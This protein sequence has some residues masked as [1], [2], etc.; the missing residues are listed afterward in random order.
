MTMLQEAGNKTSRD[1]ISASYRAQMKGS[2]M[3]IEL[4]RQFYD[5]TRSFRVTGPSGAY[6]FVDVNNAA[7]KD[8]EM[9]FDSEGQM[10]YRKPVFDLKIKAQKKNPFSR[11]EQNERAKELYGMGFFNPERAQE[12]MCALEMMDF[13]GID[14]VKEQVRQ[15]QTLLNM[16]Q[17]LNML[18][19]QLT[20][21]AMM[22]GGQAAE[23]GAAD[24]AGGETLQRKAVDAQKANMTSYGQRLAARSGPNMNAG[25]NSAM[26]GA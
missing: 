2:A 18:I 15:G 17:Q 21:A 3:C 26:P 6:Q 7:I 14:K 19:Q 11:M 8:Q 1:M 4:M 16:V 22:P 9:G 10:L 25:S 13:E 12:A 5:V 23:Q 24:P 20:G